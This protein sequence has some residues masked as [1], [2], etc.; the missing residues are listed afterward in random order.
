LGLLVQTRPLIASKNVKGGRSPLRPPMRPLRLLEIGTPHT[1]RHLKACPIIAVVDG[2]ARKAGR[3]GATAIDLGHIVRGASWLSPTF[4]AVL[5]RTSSSRVASSICRLAPP[6]SQETRAA[7]RLSRQCYDCIRLEG[8]ETSAP[9]QSVWDANQSPP[10]TPPREL[11][12]KQ[13]SSSAAARQSRRLRGC[14][15]IGPQHTRG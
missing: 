12:F 11:R 13:R 2:S 1:I 9:R 5:G 4:G 8:L 3:A 15:E 10:E 14:L 6:C 7:A